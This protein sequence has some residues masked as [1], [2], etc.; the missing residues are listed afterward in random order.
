MKDGVFSSKQADFGIFTHHCFFMLQYVQSGDCFMLV[1][2]IT[3]Q[4]SFDEVQAM[5]S[6]IQRI[7]DQDMPVVRFVNKN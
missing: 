6:W 2:D 1:Y 4:E 3:N 7:R 5:Y